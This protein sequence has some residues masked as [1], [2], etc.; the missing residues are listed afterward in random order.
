MIRANN[1]VMLTKKEFD[2]IVTLSLVKC[3]QKEPDSLSYHTKNVLK[4]TRE[5]ICDVIKE[6]LFGEDE[7]DD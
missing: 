4:W 6:M 2:F 1:N 3:S 7:C 5:E